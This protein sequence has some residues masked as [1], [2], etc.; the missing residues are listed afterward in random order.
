MDTLVSLK[1]TCE[2][3]FSVEFDVLPSVDISKPLD[4]RQERIF[5][6][7]SSVDEQLTETQSK[8][9]KLNTEVDR[10]TNHADG[11][12]YAIAVTCGIFTGMIDAIFVGEWNFEKAKAKS[13]EEVNRKVITFVK[14][15]P[16]Y[17]PWCQN[18]AH[19][20]KQR[21]PDR[22]ESAIEFLEEHF[23][24]P[25]DGAYQK[26]KYGIS[27][28]G[29][30]LDDFCHHPT[31][32]GL[33]CCIIVQFTGS[34]VYSHNT[35]KVI[36]I[37]VE[38]N[39]YGKF[40]GKNPI[41]K[42]FSG[43]V[44][45]FFNVASTLNN[46]EGHLMSDMATSAGIPGPLLST[47][48]ELS[49]LPC[50]NNANFA[51]NLRKAYQKG[52][53]EGAGQLNL[54]VF[55][56]L[57]E[58]ASSKFDK[59]TEMAIAGELKRQSLPVIINELL[60]RGGY[61]IRRFI[62]QMKGKESILEVDWKV[63][64]PFKNRTIVR[65]MTIASGTFTAVDMADAAIETAIKK[66]GTCANPATFF[67]NMILR[68]NFVGVGRM[69]ISIGTDVGMGVERSWARN[70]RIRLYTEQIALTDAKVFYKQADM[71]ISAESACETIDKAYGM[72]EK[73][74]AY[75]IES[76]QEISDSLNKIG[77][78]LPDIKK[79][80]PKLIDDINAIL[81]WE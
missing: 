67:S 2:D 78:Y 38:V 61:F 41:T 74:T 40:V 26:G 79:K 25:G 22:L 1:N 70:E 35:G 5:R 80:N 32:V 24:L 60:V 68:V 54:S 11:V 13:N 15:D 28:K 50:F 9:D 55:N 16:R 14:K 44:N 63:L 47:F 49:A 17:T 21:D 20:R 18:M 59:R 71:W 34:T 36:N 52:I 66:P 64:L 27:G 81:N 39:Q 75:Y 51:E 57:F 7:L 45:W 12:D 73:T 23:H 69:A 77:E 31:L 58:G 30:R 37:S 29:H 65:M 56:S 72:M 42:L 19:G 43:I 53:G 10:L 3:N 62:E 46:R 6:G 8:I 33:I 48:K 4:E 76:M